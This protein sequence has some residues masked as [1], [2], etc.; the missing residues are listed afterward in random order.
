MLLISAVQ[1]CESYVYVHTQ[2]FAILFHYS[3][4]QDIDCSCLC[5]EALQTPVNN[6]I[7]SMAFGE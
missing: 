4:S 6:L 1:Q 3:L 2:S 5:N 7:V